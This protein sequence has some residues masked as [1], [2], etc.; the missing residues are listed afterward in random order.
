MN[1]FLLHDLEWSHRITV[2]ELSTKIIKVYCTAI[3]IIRQ[4]RSYSHF[5]CQFLESYTGEMSNTS[6]KRPIYFPRILPL[7]LICEVWIEGIMERMHL[8]QQAKLRIPEAIIQAKV[9]LNKSVAFV[10]G[11]EISAEAKNNR[12]TKVFLHVKKPFII[13]NLKKFQITEAFIIVIGKA[14]LEIPFPVHCNSYTFD[15]LQK[16]TTFCCE[17]EI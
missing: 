16:L 13:L 2:S 14:I 8:L 4:F 10:I 6:S 11:T 15:H 1:F 17:R 9:S 5:L 7:E 3:R 12:Q